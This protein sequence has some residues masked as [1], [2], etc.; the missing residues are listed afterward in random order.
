MGAAGNLLF[1][2]CGVTLVMHALFRSP[3]VDNVEPVPQAVDAAGA[4]PARRV[5]VFVGESL[6]RA[7]TQQRRRG[8][9]PL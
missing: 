1:V 3:V 9:A 7:A 4:A 2:V 8:A 6:P 5:V